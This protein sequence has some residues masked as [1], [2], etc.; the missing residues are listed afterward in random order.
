MT[1]HSSDEYQGGC[2]CGAIRFASQAAPVATGYCHCRVCQRTSGAPVLPWGSFPVA[3]FAYLRGK[4]SVYRSSSHGQ[5]EFCTI[6]GSQLAYRESAGALTVDVNLA[7]LDHPDALEPRC[8]IWTGSRIRWF[9][10]TDAH[11][12]FE[13]A[14]PAP[15]I[16]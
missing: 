16:G 7:S 13:A 3:S 4:P 11:P 12:R 15:S 8:H 2:L 10:T 14:G 6:C 1:T 5:R 9:D